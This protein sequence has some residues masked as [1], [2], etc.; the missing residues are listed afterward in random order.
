MTHRIFKIISFLGILLIL[1]GCVSKRPLRESPPYKPIDL[2]NRIK[3]GDYVQKV[4]YF[5][6]ILDA[7]GTTKRAKYQTARRLAKGM[8]L[9]IPN[10]DLKAGLRV[11]GKSGD[12]TDLVYGMVHYTQSGFDA[13]IPAI[14]GSG[15]S[16][17]GESIAAAGL[18]FKQASN[19]IALI[20][21][22]DGLETGASSIDAAE[23]LKK[24]YGDRLCIYAVNLGFSP[25]GRAVLE[26]VTKAVQCG[27]VVNAEEIQS[28]E[29]MAG[30][31]E[32]VFLA[33]APPKSEPV[34][35]S[36]PPAPRPPS[37]P[38][39]KEVP[40][41]EPVVTP[42]KPLDS[43]HDGVPN[44]ADKCPNT[45]KGAKVDRE[46]CWALPIIYFNTAKWNIKKEFYPALNEV[47]IVLKNNPGL[48]V[49][50]E[51]HTDNRGRGPYNKKLSEKRAKEVQSYFI[52]AGVSR[53]RLTP[54]GYSE[55]RQA[56][57]NTSPENMAKN[58]RVDLVPVK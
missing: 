42:V 51:G 57:P 12:R 53:E 38:E 34:V 37:P 28:P 41:P 19:N 36:L 15:E 48:N 31:V 45:P 52:K 40:K 21:F 17:L 44:D 50:I 49:V 55:T 18:D 7:S 23:G 9:T 8:N 33:K 20:I 27:F 3:S 13:A 43:D 32:K 11:F 54:R 39:P 24:L 56:V 26:G 16:P 4:D 1:F 6:V 47:A 29:G 46:G 5:Q 22:S 30:F 14:G 2:N 35:S 25:Q 58:R 10:L